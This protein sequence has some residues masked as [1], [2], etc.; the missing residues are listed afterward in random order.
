MNKLRFP[1]VC[2]FRCMEMICLMPK[3]M[4]FQLRLSLVNLE[5]WLVKAAILGLSSVS[6]L[7]LGS[8]RK[9][10]GNGNDDTRKQ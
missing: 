10:D 5:M 9:D 1:I 3:V 6:W 7:I 2:V 4:L 8:L